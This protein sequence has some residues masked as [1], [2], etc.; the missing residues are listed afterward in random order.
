MSDDIRIKKLPDLS[1]LQKLADRYPGAKIIPENLE[2]LLLFTRV[3]GDATS[4]FRKDFDSHGLTSA[5][6]TLLLR[7]RRQPDEAMNPSEL[8]EYLG[9]T[10]ATISGLLDGL[11]K[12]GQIKRVNCPEDK[13]CCF[14]KITAKGMKLLD[15]ISPEYFSKL[16]A[17]MS[18]VKRSDM[19]IFK[20]VLLLINGRIN[21]E[22]EVKK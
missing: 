14:V 17:L 22:F 2:V 12:S 4:F 10:R 3:A 6:F 5:R 19:K 8:A 7:L 13:R 1:V 18:G 9:V 11:E 21:E 20:K 15:K 16:S